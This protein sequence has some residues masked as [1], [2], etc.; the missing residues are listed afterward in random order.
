MVIPAAA[1]ATGTISNTQTPLISTTSTRA[2]KRHAEIRAF[3]A[4]ITAG[5]IA[6]VAAETTLTGTI[7]ADASIPDVAQEA[8]GTFTRVTARI[9]DCRYASAGTHFATI[10]TWA[11]S[12]S[13]A[14]IVTEASF[15]LAPIAIGAISDTQT[16]ATLLGFA[17]HLLIVVLF[18]D[19][20]IQIIGGPA[21]TK[22]GMMTSSRHR[23]CFVLQVNQI[24]ARDNGSAPEENTVEK[25]KKHT[26]S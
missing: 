1:R 3:D 9:C 18:L 26:T 20:D 21:A 11:I 12:G 17:L 7:T 24:I 14:A 13:H 6:S 25:V 4:L 22:V 8:A 19:K 16:S 23:R 15:S 2:I 10:A 5:T